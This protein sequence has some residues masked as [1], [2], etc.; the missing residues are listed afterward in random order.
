MRI[1]R[2]HKDPKRL[3]YY[4]KLSTAL[5]LILPKKQLLLSPIT[6]TNDP[7]ENKSFSFTFSSNSKKNIGILNLSEKYSKLLRDDCKVLCFSRDYKNYQGC[8]L[9]KMWAQYGDNHRGVCL[10]L[11]MDKFIREN[12]DLITKDY[13]KEVHYSE[14]EFLRHRTQPNINMDKLEILGEET[15]IKEYFRKENL[16]FLFFTKNEEW[17]SEAEYRLIYFSKKKENEYCSIEK[18]LELIHLGVDFNDSYI[19]AIKALCSKQQILKL[20]FLLEGLVCTP[21]N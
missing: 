13:F 5:E 2:F 18:S 21:I 15:Y 12:D 14:Y 4:C 20:R 10:E 16:N 19:P 8:H 17:E 9:S 6:Q 1:I 7:R 11:N 3:Y